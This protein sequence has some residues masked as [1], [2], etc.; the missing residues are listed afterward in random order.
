MSGDSGAG[1]SGG[2]GG[3][4]SQ[5]IHNQ[6]PNA[7]QPTGTNSFSQAWGQDV[8]NLNAKQ[9]GA[10]QLMRRIGGKWYID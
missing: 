2:G 8:K 9:E 10:Y 3:N 1:S 6:D 7:G 4:L 5:C